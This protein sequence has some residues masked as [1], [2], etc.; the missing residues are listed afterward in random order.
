MIKAILSISLLFFALFLGASSASA[1]TVSFSLFPSEIRQGDPFMVQIEG[2]EISSIKKF[3]FEGKK[4]GVFLYQNKPTALIGIDLKKKPGNYE[5]RAELA[6]GNVVT[7]NVEV[8]LRDKIETPL[9][10]P[11]KLG[12]NTKTSQDKLVST[13][14]EDNK[15][16]AGLRTNVKALWK[17]PFKVP[18][19]KI[20]ITAPY[21]NSRKTGEYSIAHKGTDYRAKEGTEVMAVNRGV[22]RFTQALRNHGKTIVID[23]GMGVMSFYLHMS[24]IKVKVGEVV[25]KGQ[26][27]GL[28][29]ATGYTL[30]A[31]LHFSIRINDIAI[32]PV[33]FFELFNQ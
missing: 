24:K 33:K 26:V 13:L 6:D 11:E 7:K 18:L 19:E 22:V 20:F 14:N 30:G 21:G 28:S 8:V 10:I 3:T 25:E 17:E 16:L 27:I 29:G 31:H 4:I 15:K 32:D 5:L 2:V 9:G 12:G 1:Q 23:H